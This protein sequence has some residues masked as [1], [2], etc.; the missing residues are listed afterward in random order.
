MKKILLIVAALA[1]Q[2]GFSQE[3]KIKVVESKKIELTGN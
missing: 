2:A 1:F 3:S